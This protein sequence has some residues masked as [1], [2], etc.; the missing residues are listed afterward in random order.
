MSSGGFKP[1]VT[2]E[3]LRAAMQ[4]F[5]DERDWAQFHTP[6]NLM[7]AMTGEVGE[8]SELFMW[9][10]DAG[11]APGLPSWTAAEKEHLGEE[12][13]D[14][15][16]YLI[17]LSDRCGID[18]PS[19]A[20]AKMAKNAKKYPA[21]AARGSSAKY[22]AY[23]GAA[24]SAAGAGAGAGVAEATA[25]LGS[26]VDAT[27]AAATVS[28][29]ATAATPAADAT[30]VAAQADARVLAGDATAIAPPAA[31]P[32]K[33]KAPAA[34]TC[35]RCNSRLYDYVFVGGMYAMIWGS[36]CFA[37]YRATR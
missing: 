10:H 31:L 3:Q 25:A 22:T 17:R 26:A 35:A 21:D 37:V 9:K 33:S 19:A 32:V 36:V 12:L 13:S 24:S 2:L 4:A 6:R 7:M 16:L 29:D 18:L 1:A 15:L 23:E 30:V 34:D 20:I 14:V 5:A 28:P 8:L 11:A 27:E